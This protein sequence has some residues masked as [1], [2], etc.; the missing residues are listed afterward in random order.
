VSSQLVDHP[1]T[2]FVWATTGRSNL[3]AG[4]HLRH[5]GE[6]YNFETDVLGS[7]PSVQFIEIT[8]HLETFK[9]AWIELEDGGCP[10]KLCYA[11]KSI[12]HLTAGRD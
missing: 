3:C 2:K 8:P 5:Y 1:A 10:T 11:K 7:L 9:R 12:E 4:I 6:L